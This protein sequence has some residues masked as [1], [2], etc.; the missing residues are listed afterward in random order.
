MKQSVA[1][2]KEPLNAEE[3]VRVA[4]GLLSEKQI[5]SI[6]FGTRI[7][8]DYFVTSGTGE[9]DITV[10]A[11]SFHLALRDAGIERYNIMTYSSIM[12]GISNEIKKP[13]DL[14]HGCVVETIMACASMEK[15]VRATAG[16]IYGWLFNRKTKQRYGGLVCEYNGSLP[17][18][19]AGAQLRASLQ[20]LYTN[21]FDD[22]FELR[23]ERLTMKSFVPKKKYGTSLVAICF[24]N[25]VCPVLSVR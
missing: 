12:P 20:T 9:C 11:G 17:E 22:E 18:E 14:V 1:V 23:N 21:G 13:K 10:H 6:T 16:I 24:T 25:Y 19:E 4:E 8:K 2:L 15:G 3:V 5:S 7:P